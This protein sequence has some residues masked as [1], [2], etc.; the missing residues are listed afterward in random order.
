MINML[1]NLTE[2]NIML[3]NICMKKF[4]KLKGGKNE[5]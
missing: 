5:K 1:I 4:K 3:Y 2:N